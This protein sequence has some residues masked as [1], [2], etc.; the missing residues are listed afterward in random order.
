MITENSFIEPSAEK[1][2]QERAVEFLHQTIGQSKGEI[3][4]FPD[5]LFYAIEQL[6]RYK[7]IFDQVK[8]LP[9]NKLPLAVFHL[10]QKSADT[11][12]DV[13]Q[14]NGV[15]INSM[16]AGNLECAGRT[17]IAS[18]LFTNLGFEHMN[19]K[20]YGHSMIIFEQ[21]E[22]T[23][24]YF[25][26]NNDLYFSF[27]KSALKEYQATSALEECWL[28]EYTPREKDFYEGKNSVMRHMMVM[29]PD[30]GILQAYVNN[31]G[32]ALNGNA[33]FINDDIKEDKQ[34]ADAMHAVE[35]LL[36]R[37]QK[38][39]D[40]FYQ[41]GEKEKEREDE[42]KKLLRNQAT[43]LY[44]ASSSR[45][46]FS[47]KLLALKDLWA[48]FPYLGTDEDKLKRADLWYDQLSA[49]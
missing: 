45:E 5:H 35:D 17:M 8:E 4:S 48:S 33:E 12:P 32:A 21:D 46:D 13:V 19:A 27:P 39:P 14:G 16:Q 15:L 11:H 42:E 36:L 3:E 37:E 10:I 22:D 23:L 49:E 7:D 20:P 25:D 2:P 40:Q 43:E 24:V 26:A 18:R 28:E 44:H 34:A 31:A 6:D 29:P 47:L 30:A 41:E 38:I 9:K 1:D